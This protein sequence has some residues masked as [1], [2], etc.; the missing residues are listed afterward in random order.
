V[1]PHYRELRQLIGLVRCVVAAVLLALAASGAHATADPLYEA[2]TIVTGQEDA[3]RE[4][5]FA[6]CLRHVL[7][8]VSG[9]PRLAGDRRIVAL[10]ADTASLVLDFTYRDLM[11][12]IPV[13][14]EQGTRERPYELTVRFDPARIDAVLRALGSRP[15]TA[16]RQRI[17][18]LVDVSTGP[19]RYILTSD[20]ER[21]RDLRRALGVASYRFG[22]PVALPATA[23][24][25]DPD[26][27][28]LRDAS[29]LKALAEALG[30]AHALSGTLV[31]SDESLG[32][33][34]GWRL[35]SPDGVHQWRIDGVNFDEA[36]RSALGGAAQVLSGNGRPD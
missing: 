3:G 7:A 21:G 29:A 17:A 4:A 26:D 31:W 35:V 13:H 36:F 22:I 12:G 30:S 9:D 32:W 20:S 28:A 23:D 25:V 11:E 5:G 19:N 2:S 33:I 8:K 1:K 10:A 27:P 15:W 24:D 18:V 14:D 16:P 6:L 34:A